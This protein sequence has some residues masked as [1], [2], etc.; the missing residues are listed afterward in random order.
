MKK[1]V[2]D[3]VASCLVCQQHKYLASSPQGLLQPLPIPQAIWE[4]VSMDFIVRLPKSQ[5]HDAILVV[6]DRLSKYGHFVPLKHPYTAKTI[7]E[8]FVKEVVKLHGVPVSV[9]AAKCSPFEIV[10]GRP[11]PALTRFIP[12]E[13]AVEA[14][15]QELQTRDEALTQLRFHLTRAQDMMTK[16]ANRKRK[17]AEVKVDDWVYLKI[18]PHK[19]TSMPT[20]LHPKLSARYFGP[21]KVLQQIGKVAFKLQLPDTS[22]IHPVFHVS[23]LKIAVGTKQV[24]KDLPDE[25]QAAGP[26]FW[27]LK[28]LDRRQQQRNKELIPQILVEWQEGGKEG[29]TWE[30]VLTIQEQFPDFNLGD[31]VEHQA[32]GND[33]VWRVYER[34]KKG[35]KEGKRC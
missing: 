22:R 8:I 17:P 9:G 19:Q 2:T 18:R 11:P 30:D 10:Y 33:R 21:F 32:V 14:V 20:R 3:F 23:Q 4:E 28:I 6:V 12:G 1:A 13:T 35:N 34:K 7:A 27:P 25:L 24:E 26:M 31:K 15:A 16:Y 29:A 5:G